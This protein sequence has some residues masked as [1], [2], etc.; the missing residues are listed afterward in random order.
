MSEIIGMPEK[1]QSRLSLSFSKE[2]LAG[3]LLKLP[4][5]QCIAND[6]TYHGCGRDAAAFSC[7]VFDSH[8]SA[9]QV[10][11]KIYRK[12]HETGIERN[13]ISCSLAAAIGKL[14]AVL[15]LN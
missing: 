6:L 10:A 11:V 15:Q 8:G 5:T 4:G 13:A 14:Q 7:T 9:R 3:I 2:A 1:V 12:D